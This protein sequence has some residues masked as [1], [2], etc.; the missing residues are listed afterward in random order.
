MDV[1]LETK[2][3]E[4]TNN[5]YSIR[6]DGVIVKHYSSTQQFNPSRVTVLVLNSLGKIAY[7][8]RANKEQ[9]AKWSLSSYNRL[10]DQ[11]KEINKERAKLNRVRDKEQITKNYVL[12]II[13]EYHN[14]DLSVNTMD[15]DFYQ[16][17]KTRILIKRK[18]KQ[19]QNG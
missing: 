2:F 6:N 9:Q 16:A 14:V 12:S 15:E 1:K 11:K 7:P 13:K 8:K 10:S 19:I 3:I 17:Y 5:Q 4:G 18:I